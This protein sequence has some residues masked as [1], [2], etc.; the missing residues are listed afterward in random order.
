MHEAQRHLRGRH[1][2]LP[3]LPAALSLSGWPQD[4]DLRAQNSILLFLSLTW[5]PS[6]HSFLE[7]LGRAS[8]SLPLRIA[9]PDSPPRSPVAAPALSAPD[10]RPRRL[11]AAYLDPQGVQAGSLPEELGRPRGLRQQPP[12]R[13]TSSPSRAGCRR[14]CSPA[15]PVSSW[16]LLGGGK[17]WS[18]GLGARL[19]PPSPCSKTN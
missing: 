7:A 3:V 5:R 17:G 15:S 2:P 6:T 13:S 18:G 11:P 19:I 10:L 14:T 12:A 9:G 16:A 1:V 8:S 4:A